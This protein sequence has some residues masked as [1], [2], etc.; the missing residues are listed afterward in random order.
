MMVGDGVTPY[1]WGIIPAWVCGSMHYFERA[2]VPEFWQKAEQAAAEFFDSVKAEQEPDPFGS[3]IEI[4]WFTKLF[5]TVEGK[6][7][8]LSQD[9]A[10]NRIAEKVSMYKYLKEQESGAKRGAESLRAELLALAKDNEL[11]ALP[12]GVKIKVATRHTKEQTRK[13]STSKTITVF[14]PEGG[15]G[16]AAQHTENFIHAG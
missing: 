13:P 16:A 8:D 7:L 4:P 6:V 3:P 10:A 12:Y 9:P 5:P 1:Q 14:V 15:D 11:V 2:P